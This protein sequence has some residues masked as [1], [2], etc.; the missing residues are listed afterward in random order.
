M[1][2]AVERWVA[3]DGTEFDNK[4]DMLVHE[5]TVLDEKEIDAFLAHTVSPTSKRVTEYKKM[6]IQ[7]QKYLRAQEMNITEALPMLNLEVLDPLN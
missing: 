7:W 2:R 1:G 3:D 6:L 5:L 4:K